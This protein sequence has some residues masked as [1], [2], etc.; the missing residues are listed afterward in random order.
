MGPRA[1]KFLPS[2]SLRERRR[3]ETEA[4]AWLGTRC[5]S[6]C[7]SGTSQSPSLSWGWGVCAGVGLEMGENDSAHYDYCTGWLCFLITN[8]AKD[9][10]IYSCFMFIGHLNSSFM[11]YLFKYVSHFPW[12]GPSHWYF[13]SFSH[14][15][16]ICSLLVICMASIFYSRACISPFM[17][18]LDEQNSYFG[19]NKWRPLKWEQVEAIYPKAERA[20]GSP[21]SFVMG[22]DY[23]QAGRGRV[24][25]WG[26]LQVCSD[27]RSL[28]WGSWSGY[29]EVRHLQ[30]SVWGIY[31]PFSG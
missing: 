24:W 20:R 21:P 8:E 15:L 25:E 26:R 11:K 18:T 22:R 13:R 2:S 4:Q 28:P 27:W 3:F 30:W 17:E 14:M 16:S 10:F 12:L 5:Q 6:C 29:Q 9:G 1:G 7:L 19:R 31:L 23:K